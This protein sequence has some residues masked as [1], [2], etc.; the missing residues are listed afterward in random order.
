M[1]FD[2]DGYFFDLDGVIYLGEQVIPGAPETIAE[3][4]RRGKRVF[5][6]SN[7]SRL[8]HAGCVEKLHRFG[9]DVEPDEVLVATQATARLIAEE[10]PNARA[11]VL[12]KYGVWEELQAL[13]IDVLAP[14]TVRPEP[15]DYFVVGHIQCVSYTEL[16]CAMRSI[17]GG[18][19]FV[20]VNRDTVYPAADGP[21]PGLGG[22][23]AAVEALVGRPPDIMVGKPSTYLL[24]MALRRGNLRPE[25]CVMVGDTPETDIAAGNRAGLSTILVETGN[26]VPA[27]LHGEL[28]PQHVI[29]SVRALLD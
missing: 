6:I 21:M 25:R 3:L 28:A 10:K 24:E 22:L 26:H 13:G 5:F 7:T 4:K 2:F 15:V 27:R 1:R 12:G 8:S 11:Y 9:F 29:P 16:T 18:A 14:D 20:A 19:R 23:V 17:L